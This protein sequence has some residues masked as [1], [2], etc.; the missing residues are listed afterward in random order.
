[1]LAALPAQRDFDIMAPVGPAVHHNVASKVKRPIPPGIQTNG[2]A[3]SSK[4]S[5]SP[6]ISSK[7]PPLSAKQPPHSASE[8]SITAST[9]R[10]INRARRENSSQIAGR[11][12]RNSAGLR[13]ASMAADTAAQFA[14]PPPYSMSIIEPV[15]HVE[16]NSLVQSL[17]ITSS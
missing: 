10:P 17:P 12:S 7:K 5:P 16:S 15:V 8:R 6:S 11:N 13:S 2:N 14:A 1:M 3:Q 9:V 4:A